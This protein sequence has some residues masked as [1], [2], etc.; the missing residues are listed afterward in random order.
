MA[1]E[2]IPK[3]P[4]KKLP[5]FVDIL[6]YLSFVVLFAALSGYGGVVF[7]EGRLNKELQATKEEITKMDT[8]EVRTLEKQVRE[9]VKK[10]N[11]FAG[12]LAAHIIGSNFFDALESLTHPK[13]SFSSLNLSSSQLTAVLPGMTDGFVALGQQIQILKKGQFINSVTL[14]AASLGREGEIKFNLNLLL[15]NKMFEHK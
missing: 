15:G 12:L 4:E 10:I 11:D 3:K 8:P 5:G 14:T 9:Q 6:L 13:V 1:V 2:I 7:M